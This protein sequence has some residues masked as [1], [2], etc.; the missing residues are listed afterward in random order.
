MYAVS[1]LWKPVAWLNAGDVVKTKAG[2][3]VLTSKEKLEG[4]HTVYNFTVDATHNYLVG[5]DGVVVH[6]WRCG[7]IDKH[8]VSFINN[9]SIAAKRTCISSLWAAGRAFGGISYRGNF[10]E[11]LIGKYLYGKPY[12]QTGWNHPVIDFF[13]TI[14]ANGKITTE[15][16]SVKSTTA[17]TLEKFLDPFQEGANSSIMK[18]LDKLSKQVDL[19]FISNGSR[20]KIP[21][22]HTIVSKMTIIVDKN[23]LNNANSWLPTLRQSYPNVTFVLKTAEQVAGI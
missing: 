16:I 13:K 14:T 18:N 23:N 17:T 1:G 15:V 21:K 19:E 6:N 8:V 11:V 12:I 3:A 9:F 10:F 5:K 7:D 22:T 4:T 2:I 20:M